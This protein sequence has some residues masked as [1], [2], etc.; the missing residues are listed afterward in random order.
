M[1]N[2]ETTMATAPSADLTRSVFL[3]GAMGHG[4]HGYITFAE[5]G[6]VT[7]YQNRNE[8]FY[9]YEEGVL[10]FLNDTG[11]VTSTLAPLEGH[12]LCFRPHGNGIGSHYLEPVLTLAPTQPP[13]DAATDLPTDR[14]PVLINTLPKSGTYM[15]AQALLDIG[16]TQVDLHLSA[17]FLHDNRGVPQDEIHWSPNERALPIPAR[18][19]VALLKPGEFM[20]GHIDSPEELRA[21]QRMPVQLLNIVRT[22]YSQILSMMKF[23]QKKVKPTPKDLVWHSLTG[24]AQLKAFVI[25]HPVDYWLS[26]SQMITEEF[27]FLRFEDLRQGRVTPDGA[28]GPMAALLER[29]LH[30]AIGKRTSTLMTQ[31]PDHQI[32]ALRDP[33]IWDYLGSLGMH[34]YATRI[35]PELFATAPQDDT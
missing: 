33:V 27:P 4:P 21:I 8:A 7:T 9:R 5:D 19:A 34:D 24:M 17:H 12:P 22:P 23:R 30:T 28:D 3:F 11:S 18:A 35:W 16:Y 10:S 14:P 15:A 20:V 6:R 29:G 31:T 1:K 2:T 25:S 26:F 13:A 32:D